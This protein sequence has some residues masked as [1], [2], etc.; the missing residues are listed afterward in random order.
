M[1]EGLGEISIVQLVLAP[2]KGWKQGDAAPR[3]LYLG[4]PELSVSKRAVKFSTF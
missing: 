3:S 1:G 2:G 4:S